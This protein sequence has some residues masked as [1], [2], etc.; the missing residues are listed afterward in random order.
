VTIQ[1]ISTSYSIGKSSNAKMLAWGITA[2]FPLILLFVDCWGRVRRGREANVE[3]FA[4]CATASGSGTDEAC[5][6]HS[7]GAGFV[8]AGNNPP[9][10]WRGKA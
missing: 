2:V 3:R 10:P 5:R 7:F 6:C 9:S 8:G 1:S 4:T